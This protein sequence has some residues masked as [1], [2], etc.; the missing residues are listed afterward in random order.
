MGFIKRSLD[1][2]VFLE[3]GEKTSYE[4]PAIVS[5]WNLK[6]WK[7]LVLD[8]DITRELAGL[9][10]LRDFVSDGASCQEVVVSDST[11][12]EVEK[13]R[14]IF[15]EGLFDLV[16]SVGGG[17]VIDVGKMVAYMENTNFISIPT[18]PSNDSISSPIAVITH[19]GHKRSLGAKMPTGVIVDLTIIKGAP[20]RY[21]KS[22][23]SDVIS[24]L[25]A[26]SDWILAHEMGKDRYDT[27]AAMISESSA[28]NLLGAADND[29]KNPEF[30]QVLLKGL[31]LSGIAMGV[32]GTS[33]PS[34]GSEHEISHAI[35]ALYPNRALHGEQVGVASLFTMYLQKNPHYEKVRKLFEKLD[36]PRK[37]EHINVSRKEFVESV[38]YA[39]RT[40]PGRY[41]I[42]EHLDLKPQEIER[43][44]EKLDL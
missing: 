1:I 13:I 22:G 21:I 30:L 31:I 8:D 3:I 34:S 36:L 18:V 29:I 2:P 25:S 38:I 14:K 10:I 6:F 23:I 19:D 39:P 7:I 40:R 32:A 28:L 24:N 33:R 4:V 5:R 26:V 42:L 43:I 44:L 15:H 41:T 37:T 11:H 9:R 17:K 27:F 20:I 12:E 35:D 16:V